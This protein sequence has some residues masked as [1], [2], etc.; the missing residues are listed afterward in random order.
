MNKAINI[1]S[2]NIPYPANYGGIIDIFYRIKTL[3]EL[4]VDVI[5]HAF[6]YGREHSK[7]LNKYCK[8]VH[9]YKRKTGFSSQVSILPY[10][11]NSRRNE[12][13]I[14]NLLKNDFPILF[15]GL[16]TCYYLDDKRLENRI[17]LVRAHN[18]E[19]NYYNGLATHTKKIA[20]KI[21]FKFEAF[22]L[23]LFEKKLKFASY[24]LAV[25]KTELNYFI[26]HYGNKIILCQ[27]SHPNNKLTIT[28][29]YKPYVLYHGDLSS[30][31]NISNAVFLIENVAKKGPEIQWVIAGLNPDSSI[32]KSAKHISNVTIKANLSHEEMTT[33]LRE[34]KINILYTTQGV[35]LK[36]KLLNAIHNCHFCLANKNMLVGSGLE[37]LCILIPDNGEGILEVIRQYINKDFPEN[38]IEKRQVVLDDLVNNKKNAEK[39]IRLIGH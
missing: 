30:P 24:I 14:N 39:I 9:Y 35:G 8:E 5:L 27:S 7:E 25:S 21:Y 37:D 18:V 34:A 28:K 11:V 26:K 31:E 16:H 38:E 29:N 20:L 23:L 2:L 3:S 6:E 10:I 19:H 17:K 15:E 4:G 1:V 13:L 12:D 33:L 32:Y 36:L 22:R